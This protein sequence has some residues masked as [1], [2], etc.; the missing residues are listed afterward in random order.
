MLQDIQPQTNQVE[1][2]ITANNNYEENKRILNLYRTTGIQNPRLNQLI[3]E[4]LHQTEL[5]KNDGSVPTH[6]LASALA[7]SHRRLTGA[8]THS[9]YEAIANTMQGSPIA[10]LRLSAVSWLLSV[11]QR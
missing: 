9:Q 2:A 10:G 5:L 3:D 8:L 11:L 4:L 7:S 6:E 1:A